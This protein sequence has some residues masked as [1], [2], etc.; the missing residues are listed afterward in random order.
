MRDRWKS[1]I[2]WS[3]SSNGKL[4]EIQAKDLSMKK[5]FYVLLMI[6]EIPLEKD[7]KILFQKQNYKEH[8]LQKI[9]WRKIR[10][11]IDP[12]SL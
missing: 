7:L 10:K 5:A 4:K 6:V 1:K 11:G 2:Q 3:N 12:N 9:N 8:V